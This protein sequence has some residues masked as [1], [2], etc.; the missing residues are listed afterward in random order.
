LPLCIAAVAAIHI[1]IS[2]MAISII[3]DILAADLI[4]T[5]PHIDAATTAAFTAFEGIFYFAR[6]LHA[7]QPPAEL[8]H[9]ISLFHYY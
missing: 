8:R 2:P 7:S 3:I 9:A 5:A 4:L 1:S 6:P